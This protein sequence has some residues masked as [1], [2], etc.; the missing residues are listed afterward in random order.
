MSNTN[1]KDP[2]NPLNSNSD[3]F[4]E[5]NTP[6]QK[7][8]KSIK[9]NESITK[10]DEKGIIHDIISIRDSELNSEM[11]Q[12]KQKRERFGIIIAIIAHFFLAINQLQLKTYAKWFKPVYTMNNLLFYRSVGSAGI[13]YIFIKKKNQKI[14][15]IRKVNNKIWFYIR[16]AGSYIILLF[17]LESTTY[18]RVS[19]CQCIYGCHPII[20]L[21]LSV[22]IINEKFYWRYIF[23]MLLSFFGSILILLN[24][25]QPE[26][27][28][29][30]ENKSM[31]LGI[32]FGML[33]LGTLCFS[34]FAQKMLCKDHMT[35][36]VQTFYLGIFTGLQA[37]IFMFL[38]LQFGLDLWYILYC[39][40]NGV[41]FFIVNCLCALSMENLAISK[42][43]PITYFTVVFIF[44]LGWIVL[45]EKVYFTDVIGSLFILGFQIF[46]VWFPISKM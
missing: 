28:S 13:S 12:E 25:T 22:I 38:D 24:E 33:Y 34:K 39:L 32:I 10:V 29:Q 9:K 37:M 44:V 30:S 20:V 36:E 6:N 35:P 8:S 11:K 31:F 15:D 17:Y 5:S 18:F 2:L 45:G 21:V 3:Q 26:Q 27:R 16:E 1:L 14:P 41:I 40:L 19:T 46:N 7:F 43:L 4:L 23:G 42:Y